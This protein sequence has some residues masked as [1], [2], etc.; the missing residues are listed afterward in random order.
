MH[1]LKNSPLMFGIKNK[2]VMKFYFTWTQNGNWKGFQSL[3]SFP[4]RQ[5]LTNLA[6]KRRIFMWTV[7]DFF[8]LQERAWGSRMHWAPMC[9]CCSC[10]STN[11]IFRTGSVAEG[12]LPEKTWP[13]CYK[14]CLPAWGCSSVGR[15]FAQ[16]ARGSPGF[17]PQHFLSL[18]ELPPPR[19]GEALWP[20]T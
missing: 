9:V 12:T 8:G 6:R 2:T 5:G 11:L 16:I 20:L 18:P 4:S 1:I 14:R 7:T 10:L 17:H 15:M 19:R 13:F 3:P